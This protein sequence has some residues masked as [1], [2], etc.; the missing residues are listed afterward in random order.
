MK[1]KLSPL[2][3]ANKQDCSLNEL[4]VMSVLIEIFNPHYFNDPS[5][6]DAILTTDFCGHCNSDG[7]FLLSRLVSHN[8]NDVKLA[9]ENLDEL[10]C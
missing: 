3:S 1:S 2:S 4:R 9:C 7:Q 8:E 6:Y 10:N 5:S